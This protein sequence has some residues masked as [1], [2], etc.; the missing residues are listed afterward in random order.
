MYLKNWHISGIIFTIIAGTLL[1]FFY[2][3]SGNWEL[4]GTFS[5][6]NESTWEHLKLIITPMVVF[7]L[8]EYFFYGKLY[9]GFIMTKLISILLGM[10]I[11]IALFYTYSGILGDN[12][13]ICDIATF[14]ISVIFSYIFSYNSIMKCRFCFKYSDIIGI[15]G[16]IILISCMIIFTFYPPHIA[17]F[18]DPCNN[19]YGI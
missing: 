8:V 11:I 7:S 3:W 2:D 9:D 10:G 6:V 17:L 18:K 14:I 4:I 1:H 13:L 15:A 12:Y 16:F 19:S 5:A